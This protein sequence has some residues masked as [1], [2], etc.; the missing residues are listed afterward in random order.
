MKINNVVIDN[1]Q[2]TSEKWWDNVKQDPNEELIHATMQ[3]ELSYHEYMELL[4]RDR[5]CRRQKVTTEP[6]VLVA[7]AG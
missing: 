7:Q 2:T 6:S 1:F 3:M 4:D 5:R